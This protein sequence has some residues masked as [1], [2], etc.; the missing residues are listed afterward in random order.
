VR[1]GQKQPCASA[2]VHQVAHSEARVEQVKQR[3]PESPQDRESVTAA[4]EIRPTVWLTWCPCVD[5]PVLPAT[6]DDPEDDTS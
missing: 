1:L 3:R 5:L 4:R 2:Q 6:P